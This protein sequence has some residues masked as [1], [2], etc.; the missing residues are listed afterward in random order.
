METNNQP[1]SE[2]KPRG[3]AAMSKEARIAIAK[4]GGEAVSKDRTYMAAIGSKGGQ[5]S[6]GRRRNVSL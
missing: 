6:K 4:K 1:Q 2:N 5:K 3:F